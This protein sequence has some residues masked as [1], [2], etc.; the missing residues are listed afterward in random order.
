MN[1]IYF[2]SETQHLLFTFLTC[3]LLITQAYIFHLACDVNRPHRKLV[4]SQE[5]IILC[6]V[7]AAT[8]AMSTPII[9]LQHG[10]LALDKYDFLRYVIGFLALSTAFW[11]IQTKL[12]GLL[13][14]VTAL[15]SFPWA[16]NYVFCFFTSLLLSKTFNK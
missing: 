10:D 1:A 11:G 7:L 12:T 6:F 4:L 5:I 14:V 16:D 8:L 3:L 13:L 2:M 15:M 9:S